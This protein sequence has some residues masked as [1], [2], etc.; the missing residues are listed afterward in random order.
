VSEKHLVECRQKEYEKFWPIPK[1]HTDLEQTEK[2]NQR[3]K[4]LML[5]HLENDQMKW[6]IVYT[7]ARYS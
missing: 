1:G 5:V 7:D 4:W 2:K 3:G 6:Y